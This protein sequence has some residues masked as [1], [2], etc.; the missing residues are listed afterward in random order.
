MAASTL[1]RPSVA[2][3]APPED[4]SP[5]L[6]DR[7]R[8]LSTYLHADLT[9]QQQAQRGRV[10]GRTSICRLGKRPAAPQPANAPG[11]ATRQGTHKSTPTAPVLDRLW[12]EERFAEMRSS[13]DQLAEKIPTARLDALEFQFHA[14]METLGSARIRRVP[15]RRWKRG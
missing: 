12:F 3:T 6:N 2:K 8:E 13:I 11:A 7:L 9:K 1:M 10:P 15:W 14:L 4:K 5:A